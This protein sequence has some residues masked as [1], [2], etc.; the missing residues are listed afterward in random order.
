MSLTCAFCLLRDFSSQKMYCQL[1][2]IAWLA[3]C[4][5]SEKLV[6]QWTRKSPAHECHLYISYL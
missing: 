2:K 4:K 3:V 5:L 6:W 1:V